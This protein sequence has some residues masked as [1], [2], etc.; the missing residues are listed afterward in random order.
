MPE[1]FI[2]TSIISVMKSSFGADRPYMRRT[3]VDQRYGFFNGASSAAKGE[4][5]R[6]PEARVLWYELILQV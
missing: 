5:G 1:P 3:L 2:S 4:A 6:G